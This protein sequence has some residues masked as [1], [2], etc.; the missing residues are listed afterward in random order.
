MGVMECSR[1]DC[2]SVLCDTYVSEV[3]F[4]CYECKSEFKKYMANKLEVT[5]WEAG[6]LEMSEGEIIGHLK[7]FMETNKSSTGEKMTISDFFNKQ[8]K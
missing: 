7:E 8:T 4:M 1:N 3:G 6:Q 2:G 5:D